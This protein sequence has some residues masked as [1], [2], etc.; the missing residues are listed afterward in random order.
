MASAQAGSNY[1]WRIQNIWDIKYINISSLEIANSY[2]PSL[3]FS[4]NNALLT[5]EGTILFCIR[6]I[7]RIAFLQYEFWIQKQD[8]QST[9]PAE[10]LSEDL[11]FEEFV[12]EEQFIAGKSVMEMWARLLGDIRHILLPRLTV[13]FFLLSALST[14]LDYR[15]PQLS[16]IVINSRWNKVQWFSLA[17]RRLILIQINY[18]F[19][20]LDTHL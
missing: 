5:Q 2:I 1:I 9:R 15:S 7:Y 18:C 12:C 8:P 13:E 16:Y 10:F 17:K 4:N 20:S 6:K 11:A 3:S 19:L 14:I